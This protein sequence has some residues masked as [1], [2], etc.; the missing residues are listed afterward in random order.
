MQSIEI[1]FSN[2]SNAIWSNWFIVVFLMIGLY[3]T[4][5]TKFVQ[6][7]KLPYALYESLIKPYKK[8][9]TIK[10]EGTITPFQAMCTGLA[11]CVGNGNIVGVATAIIGGGPGAIFWMW[12]AGILGMA[13]KYAE[14]II[15]IVYR[16]KDKNG[17]YV[18]GPIYYI[19]KG[20]KLPWMAKIFAILLVIQ[21]TG[22][23]LIQSNAVANVVVDM[24]KVPPILT[25]I[26]LALLIGVIIIGG[27]KRLGKFAEVIVPIM[28][29]LY[30]VGGLIVIG[31]NIEKFPSVIKLIFTSAF[32][33]R[34][35]VSG[36]IGYSIREAMKFGVSRGL[37]SNEAGEGSAPVVHS[38]AITDHPARQALFGIT[39]VFIDTIILCSLTAFVILSSGVLEMNISP[40]TI[41]SV[42]FGK[43]HPLL[44]YLVGISM[45][46]FAYSTIPT[47]WY[48]GTVGL[49]YVIGEKKAEVYKYIFLGVTVIG[50]IS[51]LPLVWSIMDSILGILI[52]P[53]LIAII[54]LSPI[55]LKY[56]N[57]F[58]NPENGYITKKII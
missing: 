45:V 35:G 18:G 48:F 15:G 29:L 56:T 54:Y 46:L 9:N 20:L 5:L 32:T 19:A 58:F 49:S 53:N 6:F 22:G 8:N 51:S 31:F 42:A 57:E 13:T 17:N 33:L 28:A 14:I 41:V 26:I 3:F 4:V 2:L 47:Q 27:I 23:N 44:R 50:S 12:I 43:I 25:G 16:E 52:I 36:A 37:Y 55:V 40:A 39:E 34:A 10:G 1:F 30:I 21:C 7:R 38:T 11:G 24:F